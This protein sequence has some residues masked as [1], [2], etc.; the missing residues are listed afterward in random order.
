[1]WDEYSVDCKWQ[2]DQASFY[3][4]LNF[5]YFNNFSFFL[6]APLLNYFTVMMIFIITVRPLMAECK[7]Q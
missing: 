4:K 5:Y 7:R 6:L 1:M 3:H 2:T